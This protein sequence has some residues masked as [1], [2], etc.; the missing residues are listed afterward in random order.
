MIT[1]RPFALTTFAAG[2]Y[3]AIAEAIARRS[4]PVN[5]PTNPSIDLRHWA[6]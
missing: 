3:G 2:R 6:V 4:S 1:V 5:A